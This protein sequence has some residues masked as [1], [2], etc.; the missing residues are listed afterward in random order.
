[1]ERH[2]LETVTYDLTDQPD[3]RSELRRCIANH[4]D[5]RRVRLRIKGKRCK[6]E[7]E[8]PDAPVYYGNSW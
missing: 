3:L 5:V 2:M 1:M 7:I 6:L 4:S 8:Q